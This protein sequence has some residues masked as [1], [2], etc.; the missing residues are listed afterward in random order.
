[1]NTAI[2]YY[3]VVLAR[4]VDR[5]TGERR[6][7][8]ERLNGSPSQTTPDGARSMPAAGTSGVRP[9]AASSHSH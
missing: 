1:M 7:R 4:E 9:S 5:D 6:R 2:T 8:F 3:G